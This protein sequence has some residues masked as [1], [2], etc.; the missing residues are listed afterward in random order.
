MERSVESYALVGRTEEV[1]M[2]VTDGRELFST[3][4]VDQSRKPIY[5]IE[6]HNVDTE[7]L[8]TGCIYDVSYQFGPNKK[9]KQLMATFESAT[10][11]YRTLVFVNPENPMKT[12]GI[13]IM[14]IIYCRRLSRK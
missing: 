9:V 6:G 1:F 5:K 12:I 3:N 10:D 2:G 11:N 8:H 4:I 13:P 14:N 7:D